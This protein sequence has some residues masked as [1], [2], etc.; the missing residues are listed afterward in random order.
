MKSF[1]TIAASLS[2]LLAVLSSIV[3]AQETQ[4]AAA[5]SLEAFAISPAWRLDV[6]QDSTGLIPRTVVNEFAGGRKP[7]PFP[8][9]ELPLRIARTE[10]SGNVGGRPSWSMSVELGCLRVASDGR[11]ALTGMSLYPAN[12]I[13]VDPLNGNIARLRLLDP[14]DPA[15]HDLAESPQ[16]FD[17]DRGSITGEI[18]RWELSPD[19]AWWLVHSSTGTSIFRSG[20]LSPVAHFEDRI[21]YGGFSRDGSRYAAVAEREDRPSLSSPKRRW[22]VISSTGAVLGE[23]STIAPWDLHLTPDG[24]YLTFQDENRGQWRYVPLDTWK[25]SPLAMPCTE[26]LYYSGDGRTALEV[27]SSP[28][29]IRLVDLTKPLTPRLIGPPIST[30]GMCI[31]GALSEKGEWAAVQVAEA[32]RRHL[33]VVVYDRKLEKSVVLLRNTVRSGLQFVGNYLII[34]TQRDEVPAYFAFQSTAGILVY[35]VSTLF[36]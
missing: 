35:D 31:T 24:R 33:R 5:D 20:S 8:V 13:A 21:Y 28:G 22:I 3:H 16:T 30:Q 23:G 15:P 6:A 17:I 9:K 10:T 1:P 25:A 4:P 36:K 29:I 32:D 26:H 11:I 34:G 18:Y 19:R 7:A 12:Q 2:L 27:T 14:S